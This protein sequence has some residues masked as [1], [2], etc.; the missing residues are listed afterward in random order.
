ML[1]LVF[2]LQVFTKAA[3]IKDFEMEGMSIGDSLLDFFEESEIKKNFFYKN[4]KY[5]AFSSIKYSSENYNGFQF[6][7]KNNDKRYIIASIEGI[8]TFENNFDECLKYKDRIVKDILKDLGNLK[9][10][11]DEGKHDYDTTGKSLY[12][13]T[14]IMLNPKAKYFNLQVSCTDWSKELEKRFSDKLKVSISTD[15]FAD[16]MNNEA[17]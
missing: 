17:Y 5:F 9:V 16:Y 10:K 6:H 11:T 12:Y 1:V 4:K 14:S 8:K 7:A 3:D 15:V 13:R 2:S